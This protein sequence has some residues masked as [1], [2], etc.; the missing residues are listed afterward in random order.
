MMQVDDRY[1]GLLTTD[2][3]DRILGGLA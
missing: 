3:V 2:K 1:D